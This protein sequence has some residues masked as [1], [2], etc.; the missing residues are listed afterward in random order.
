MSAFRSSVLSGGPSNNKEFC[1]CCTTT[2]ISISTKP[3]T[4]SGTMSKIATQSSYGRV[5]GNAL[6]FISDGIE[7]GSMA[8]CPA[9]P[10]SRKQTPV[11]SPRL[12]GQRPVRLS[13]QSISSRSHS[14]RQCRELKYIL[15]LSTISSSTLLCAVRPRCS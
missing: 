14:Q 2:T 4:P 9:P 8:D 15:S 7:F 1:H 6:C 3:E 5:W 12:V 13:H 11:Q 10:W